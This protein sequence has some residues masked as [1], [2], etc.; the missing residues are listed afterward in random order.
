MKTIDVGWSEQEWFEWTFEVPDD[1][2]VNDAE[3]V[4]TLIAE[5]E[6]EYHN[7][8]TGVYEDRK[9]RYVEVGERA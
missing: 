5:G 2:D 3:A 9:I 8:A 7:A 1:F 4:M 6:I